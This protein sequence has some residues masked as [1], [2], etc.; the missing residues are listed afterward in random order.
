[1]SIPVFLV[2][3]PGATLNGALVIAA[4]AG[5]AGHRA[6]RR[7][8]AGAWLEFPAALRNAG[9]VSAAVAMTGLEHA[10]TGASWAQDAGRCASSGRCPCWRSRASSRTSWR[11]TSRSD[12][13]PLAIDRAQAEAIADAALK[14]RGDRR[15]DRSGS[16]CRRRGWR[17]EDASSWQWHK[18]VWREAGR[19]A[20]R[21]A[22]RQLARATAV[23]RSLCAL[24]QRR[25][26]RSRRGVADHRRRRRQ[27]AP[28]STPAAGTARR[29]A[30]CRR[31]M[32]AAGAARRSARRFGL[33]PAALREVSAEQSK[34]DRR[35]RTGSSRS[36][37]RASTSAKA[38]RRARSSRSPATRS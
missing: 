10:R 18:F 5:A 3:G 16:A 1:M 37:I 38:A 28:G 36:P 9:W 34:R 30:I 4:G 14:A 26:R 15:S 2:E 23:G 31:T 17:R 33:D 29:R 19:D 21:R 32:R 35:A 20:Y 11:A 12:A 22:D 27:G 13:P 24:R 6:A 7:S 8:A 25:R